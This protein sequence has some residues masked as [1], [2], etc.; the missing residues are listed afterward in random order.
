MPR[1]MRDELTG[2]FLGLGYDQRMRMESS[3]LNIYDSPAHDSTLLQSTPT[4]LF[5]APAEGLSIAVE[6]DVG[7]PRLF[8]ANVWDPQG[9]DQ[10]DNCSGCI[11]SAGNIYHLNSIY[12]A[13][14]G[15]ALYI[16]GSRGGPTIPDP[17]HPDN[18]S[19]PPAGSA[20]Q[21]VIYK[22]A[23]NGKCAEMACATAR[24]S[25]CRPRTRRPAPS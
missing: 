1:T 20:Y 15:G 23:F 25:D 17:F 24:C 2:D 5:P 21:V 11:E 13:S 18:P 8:P 14:A 4:D 7:N 9:N 6:D 12:L 16:A 22:V 3:F 19:N 10:Y